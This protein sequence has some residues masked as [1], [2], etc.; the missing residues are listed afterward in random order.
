MTLH[1]PA[2]VDRLL[3]G[4]HWRDRLRGRRPRAL[5]SMWA[6]VRSEVLPSP[7]LDR[8]TDTVDLLLP[9]VTLDPEDDDHRQALS[10]AEILI[11]SWGARP[12][13][14]TLLRLA[15]QLR[16]IFHAAGSVKAYVDESVWEREIVVSSAVSVGARPVADYTFAMITL[17]GKKVGALTRAYA[18]TGFP[19]TRG[20][21]GNLGLVVGIVGA[22]SV[23]SLVIEHLVRRGYVVLVYDPVV[24]A[25][26]IRDQGA[27]SVELDDLC[28]RSAVVS[29]H[30]PEVPSTRHLL[31]ARRISL[32]RDG[33]VVINT[34]RGSLVD[35]EALTRASAAGRIDA[36]LD[37]TSPEPLPVGHRLFSLDNVVITPHVAGAQGTE[38]AEMGAFAIDEVERFVAGR[39]LL[40]QVNLARMPVIA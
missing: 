11:T 16:G 1:P 18:D 39:A 14:H 23:G 37:V 38:I 5:L 27:T 22:S 19:A 26:S 17:V 34:A 20:R 21:R 4:R 32:L 3:D 33:C 12:V 10:R 6:D 15:P 29:L 35:T 36:I 28:L 13:D 7:L 24:S 9:G 2:P 40:G 31:D 30:A 8:L 25:D